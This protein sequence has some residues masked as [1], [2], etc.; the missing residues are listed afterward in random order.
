MNML[1]K[2][3]GLLYPQEIV[4]LELKPLE[5]TAKTHR[6]LLWIIDWSDY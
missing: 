3:M 2:R 1:T 6:V 5:A 4:C